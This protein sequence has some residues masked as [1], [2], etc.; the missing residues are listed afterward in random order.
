MDRAVALFNEFNFSPHYRAR[1]AATLLPYTFYEFA[2]RF[3]YELA[4]YPDLPDEAWQSVE[5][6][7]RREWKQRFQ[8]RDW[9]E[10]RDAVR[11]AWQIVKN[12]RKDC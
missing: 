7:A 8:D 6:K 5:V 10:F 3:G 2:Y 11:C 1:Y 12:A 9:F 4:M